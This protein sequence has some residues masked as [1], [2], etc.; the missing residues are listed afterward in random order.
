M[1]N[2]DLQKQDI[3]ISLK[4]YGIYSDDI[5]EMIILIEMF[6]ILVRLSKLMWLDDQTEND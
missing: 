5:S 2:K 4:K 1:E 3:E 6:M